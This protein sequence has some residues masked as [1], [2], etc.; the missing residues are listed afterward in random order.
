ML[1]VGAVLGRLPRVV[2]DLA[3]SL[4]KSVEMEITGEETELD[5]GVIERIGDPLTHL[6]RNAVDHGIESPAERQAAGKPAEGRVRVAAY[7]SGGSVVIEI[8]DDGKGLDAAR[9]RAKAVERGLIRGGEPLTAEQVQALIFEPGF[10]TAEQVT[11]V[12]GRGVGMDVVKRNVEALNG[13][14]AVESTAGAGTC[15]RIRLP[16]TLAILDGMALRVA[17]QTFVLPLLSIVESFRPPANGRHTLLGQGEVVRVRGD[18]VPLVRLHRL[19]RIPGAITD[20]SRALVVTVE[21]EGKRMGL[22]VD[23]LLGQSQ[24]VIKSLEAHFRR[25]DGAMG[26]TILAD[27]RVALILDVQGLQRLSQSTTEGEA[28]ELVA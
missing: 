7:H 20:P 17:D 25:V 13:S 11:D 19:F 9:I 24:V 22:L 23:E 15:F 1:P 21:H 5:K 8:S 18:S 27:G 4:G 10:S 28:A 16:L 6:V 12:S 3:A 2:R 14:V 26:A